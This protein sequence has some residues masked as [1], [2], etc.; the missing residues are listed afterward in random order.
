MIDFIL[1]VL[2]IIVRVLGFFTGSK[3]KTPDDSRLEEDKELADAIKRGDAETVER[4]RERRRKYPNITMILFLLLFFILGCST[5]KYIPLT[6]GNIPYQ[7]PAGKYID[8]KGFLHDEQFVRWSLSEEDLF[9]S[10]RQIKPE[11]VSFFKE[12]GQLLITATG[13]ILFLLFCRRKT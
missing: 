12:N 4:I 13:L 10:T 6:S 8:A 9:N 3:Q 5:T 7:L 11:K 1:K 2:G